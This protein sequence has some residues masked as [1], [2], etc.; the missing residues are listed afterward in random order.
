MI[1]LRVRHSLKSCFIESLLDVPL[2]EGSTAAE[3]INRRCAAGPLRLADLRGHEPLDGSWLARCSQ[4]PD[5][6]DCAPPSL[7]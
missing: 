1:R 3:R 6:P 5:S 7:P 4:L 2:P